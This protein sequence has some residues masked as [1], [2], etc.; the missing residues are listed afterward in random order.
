MPGGARTPTGVT[1]TV[2]AVG[3]EDLGDSGPTNLLFRGEG[4]VAGV[5]SCVVDSR[6][7]VGIVTRTRRRS[8]QMRVLQHSPWETRG[9][10][11]ASA[12]SSWCRLVPLF[13]QR[14]PGAAASHGHQP[15][16]WN[17]AEMAA[18]VSAVCLQGER[19]KRDLPGAGSVFLVLTRSSQAR[20]EGAGMMRF[21]TSRQNDEFLRCLTHRFGW[22]RREPSRLAFP[23]QGSAA[24]QSRIRRR[25]SICANAGSAPTAGVERADRRSG[26][27][28]GVEATSDIVAIT[29]QAV[30][31]RGGFTRQLLEAR[32][33]TE[34]TR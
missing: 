24:V 28:G 26:R 18:R 31:R 2:R 10:M 21:D 3:W 29:D 8:W 15:P 19:R 33:V 1:G 6:V 13:R 5:P 22:V 16:G 17:G 4:H 12:R 23:A 25:C 9:W 30:T 14:E 34:A 20:D 11:R 32:D 27:P 7:P